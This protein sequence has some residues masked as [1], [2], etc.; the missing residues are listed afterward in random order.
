MDTIEQQTG[1]YFKGMWNLSPGELA[2]W[3]LVDEAEQQFNGIDI[4]A[5]ATIVGGLNIIHVPGKPNTAT[6]GT[7]IL[8]L[9]LRR[10]ISY[11]LDR[12]WRSPTWKTLI[13]GQWARTARW[14][15]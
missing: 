10:M 8:S 6:S 11:R 2:F 5:F 4:F 15:G 7:S 14:G 13:N 12:R 3:I 9:S 1:Y